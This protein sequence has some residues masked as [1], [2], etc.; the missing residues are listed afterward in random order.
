MRIK[1]YLITLNILYACVALSQTSDSILSVTLDDVIVK[2][3]RYSSSVKSSKDGGYIWKL[4]FL[5]KLPKIMGNADPMHYAHML[6]GVQTNSEYKA[7]INIQGSENSHNAILLNG[8][9][10]YNANH[11]LGFFSVFNSSHFSTMSLEKMCSVSS[12]VN[13]IGGA[14]LLQY[15]DSIPDTLEG[16]LSVGLIS[17]QGTF[18]LP[19]GTKTKATFSLRASYL[20]FLYGSW[21]KSDDMSLQYSFADANFTLQHN[22]NDY[23]TFLIDYYGGHDKGKFD[24]SDAFDEAMNLRSIWGNQVGAFHWKYNNGNHKLINTLY[25]TNYSNA[26]DLKLSEIYGNFPSS[27]SD[28]GFKSC[29]EVG[30][31]NTGLDIIFHHIFPQDIN[32]KGIYD[33]PNT[34]QIIQN[35]WE[36]TF[37]TDYEHHFVNCFSANV[38]A[39]MI[40]YFTHGKNFFHLDPSVS[41]KYDNNITRLALN[42][43]YGHQ[44]LFQTG[45]SNV[46]LPVEFWLSADKNNTPQAAH[47]LSLNASTSLFRRRYRLYGDI[48]YK[49]LY[50]QIE[51]GGNVFDVLNSSYSLQDNLLH[52]K[53]RN[54]GFSLMLH[55][56][57]GSLTGWV[58]Y[59]YTSAKRVFKEMDCNSFFPA[60]HERPHDFKSV[61]MYSPWKHWD[62]ATTVVC[63]SGTPFTLPES[64]ALIN[65]NIL[66]QYGKYNSNRLQ[67]YFRCDI[68][69]N[70]KLFTSKFKEQGINIS[71]YNVSRMNNHLFW[72][73]RVNKDGEFAY[74]PVSF[75]VKQLPSISYYCKF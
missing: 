63:A 68:S 25:T 55:K 73:V 14:L 72:K 48:F 22:L 38:G 60:S 12:G 19:F 3:Y 42:Y 71:I 7:G 33:V 31:W 43:A 41:L 66:T 69:V 11:L 24:D 53:G 10:I 32:L 6:P 21:L 61:V 27:I 13:R 5:N 26:L 30:K 39:K 4:P 20:N 28:I 37:H 59:T 45:F 64:I 70:Y 50:N 75:V 51:Y 40:G 15:D 23:H 58:S 46:G 57:T 17:A 18:C 49:K 2:S 35:T 52:G 56:C 9:P 62:F 8:V 44:Y 65:G 36:T 54:Y 29:L 67:P 47:S 74:R 16:D 34:P 1:Y